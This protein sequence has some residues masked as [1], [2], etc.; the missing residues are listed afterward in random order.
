[1]AE[2]RIARA[3]QVRNCQR[4]RAVSLAARGRSTIGHVWFLAAFLRHL[5]TPRA[6]VPIL[7]LRYRAPGYRGMGA[8]LDE[9]ML[10]E[11][12]ELQRTWDGSEKMKR[13]ADC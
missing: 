11:L 8:T 2:G 9:T 13:P 1:M 6:A 4:L 5:R 7:S 3:L 10:T 12:T